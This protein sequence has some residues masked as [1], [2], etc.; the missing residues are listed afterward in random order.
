MSRIQFAILLAVGAASGVIGG[1]LG[2]T[3]LAPTATASPPA[4]AQNNTNVL[5]ARELVL[6]DAEGVVVA[7]LHIRDKLPMLTM[8]DR[9]GEDRLALGLD[10]NGN[11]RLEMYG[12]N[13]NPTIAVDGSVDRSRVVA[14][15]DKGSSNN[16]FYFF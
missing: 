5:R 1:G 7:T 14:S 12:P 6:E 10:P 3:L 16:N 9:N 15:H 2:T 11:G 4:T 13:G 8:F